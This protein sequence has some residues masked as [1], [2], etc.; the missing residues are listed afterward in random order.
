MGLGLGLGAWGLGQTNSRTNLFHDKLLPG[1]TNSSTNEFRY[2]LGAN[3]GSCLGPFSCG[4]FGV[5]SWPFRD[6]FGVNF[7]SDLARLSHGPA[8]GIPEI[9][10]HERRR[11]SSPRTAFLGACASPSTRMKSDR[12]LFLARPGGGGARAF[13]KGFPAGVQN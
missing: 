7:G 3:L 1:Q 9:G 11:E 4:Q 8:R 12:M 10:I 13:V 5:N 6:Q 2:K